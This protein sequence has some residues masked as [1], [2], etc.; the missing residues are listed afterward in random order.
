[1]AGRR[2]DRKRIL[3]RSPNVMAMYTL[4]EVDTADGVRRFWDLMA[5]KVAASEVFV[6]N[7]VTAGWMVNGW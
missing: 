1:M 5:M 2:E 3:P 4:V 7:G 6:E